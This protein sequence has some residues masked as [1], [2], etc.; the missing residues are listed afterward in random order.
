VLSN[1][2]T[3]IAGCCARAASGRRSPAETR[4][5][6][7]AFDHSITSSALSK[8]DCGTVRPSALAVLRFTTISSFVGSI[9]HLK[10]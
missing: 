10:W 5:E 1:P 4:D 2:T 6:L 8:I 3:G 9:C 7:P